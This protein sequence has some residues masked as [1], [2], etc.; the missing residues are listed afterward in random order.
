MRSKM[1]ILGILLVLLGMIPVFAEEAPAA[2][3]KV[4]IA[5]IQ[6]T[7]EKYAAENVSLEG[8]ISSQ[9]GSGCWFVLTDPTGDIYVDLKPHNFVIPPAMGKSVLVNGSILTKNNDLTFVGNS[10]NLDGKSYS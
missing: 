6:N 9:C 7:P 3:A 2:A 10:V 4:N 8:K 5:D 1:C